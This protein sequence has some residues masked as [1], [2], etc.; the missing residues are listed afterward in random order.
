MA[1]I[2]YINHDGFY[3]CTA[4]SKPERISDAVSIGELPPGNWLMQMVGGI[5]VIVDRSGN[6]P[7]LYI[8]DGELAPLDVSTVT[9]ETRQIVMQLG[10]SLCKF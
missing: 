8:R 2:Y 3:G 4:G 5:I 1:D 6:N 7:P 9:E 10:G